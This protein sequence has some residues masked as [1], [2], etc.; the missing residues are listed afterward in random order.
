MSF[1]QRKEIKDI[2]SYFRLIDNSDDEEA[3]MRIINYPTRGIGNITV[4]KIVGLAHN[5]GISLW[6]LI[7]N[8]NEY[9]ININK[10]TY[11]KLNSFC[12]L[13]N[14]FKEKALIQIF[15]N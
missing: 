14:S 4:N 15:M 3:F 8:L 13:I 11:E 5:F 7:N 6:S 10:S 12:A 2:I 1:Y 9:P